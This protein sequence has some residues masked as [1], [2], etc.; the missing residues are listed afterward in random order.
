MKIHKILP[1]LALALQL[2]GCASFSSSTDKPLPSTPPGQRIE[3]I[4]AD[5]LPAH[6]VVGTVMGYSIDMLKQRA[7]KLGADAIINPRSVDPVSGWATTQA[8]KYDK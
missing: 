4:S 7:R 6:R 5:H 3:V 1:I 8:I 2:A